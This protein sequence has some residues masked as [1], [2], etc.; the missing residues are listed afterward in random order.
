MRAR[1]FIFL[2][3]SSLLINGVLTAQYAP[4]E[5]PAE[6]TF[7]E[8]TTAY[9]IEA[10]HE[11]I[12]TFQP[13]IEVEVTGE[14]PDSSRWQVR[15]RRFGQ[16]DIHSQIDLP[17][18]ARANPEAFDRI[19]DD[20][21]A[22]PAL[23]KMLEAPEPW[24]NDLVTLARR[25][26]PEGS[27]RITG[28]SPEQPTVL[29]SAASK[30]GLQVWG[31]DPLVVTL[32]Y[33]EPA[34]PLVIFEI[35]NKGDAFKTEVNAPRAYRHFKERLENIQREFRF[36]R[37]DPGP[38]AGGN[39]ITAIR[40]QEEAY[41]LPN[42]LRVSLRYDYGEYLL[43]VFQSITHLDA[44]EPEPL[45]LDDLKDR[46][47]SKVEVSDAGHRFVSDIPMVNQGEKGYC[48]AATLAR[49][50][51]FY[52]YSVDQHALADLAQTEA[53]LVDGQRG[54]TLR[55]NIVKAMRR[56]TGSTPFR[57][58]ELKRADPRAIQEIIDQ[59]LPIIWFVPGHARLLI[60][61]DP[62]SREIVFSDT[63]GLEHAYK[64]ASWNDFEKL[65]QEMWYLEFQD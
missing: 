49:V 18:L 6:W 46:L 58:K 10:P 23:R 63:W 20:I 11:E 45:D 25:L 37:N 19:E 39:S 51:Q 5:R 53:Q 42:D 1:L 24:P 47:A 54:G 17:N 38:S 3:L 16:A 59:G 40:F 22:F 28:G 14:V 61:I 15:F 4:I 44:H 12:G 33:R 13:G 50:L 41:L 21:A 34:S 32:N 57:L 62:K 2:T 55:N 27:A 64:V 36:N 26:L 30:E 29:E 65:N 60:G 56:I 52:G 48:A 7:T 43:V 9:S 8:P 31:V 35:W